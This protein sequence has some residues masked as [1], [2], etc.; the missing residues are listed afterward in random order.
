M[1]MR[2]MRKMILLLAALAMVFAL[3]ACGS[4]GGSSEQGQKEQ[5]KEEPKEQKKPETPDKQVAPDKGTEEKK[6]ET[7]EG[8]EDKTLKLTI[9]QMERI[10]DDTIPN[11]KGTRM[12]L[13]KENAA[14]HIAGTGFPWEDEANIYI[15]GHR[16][17]F[18]GTNSWL[19]FY[20]L[21]VLEN[22]DE[23]YLT[24]SEGKKYTYK[25]FEKKIVEPTDLSVMKPV[26]G[27]NILSLQTC[28]LP[29]YSDR[30]VYHAE[31]QKS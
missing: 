21:E 29:D 19:A 2:S 22:G 20:D 5:P 16:L 27:K 3:A 14:V 7:A 1:R 23:V 10:K 26:K 30:V 6:P 18:E 24:D 4:S 8:P 13:F 9:P 17:G 28:T 11:G 31:L 25:I 15:A 12:K